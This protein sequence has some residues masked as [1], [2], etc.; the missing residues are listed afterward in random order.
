MTTIA[1]VIGWKFNHQ[2]GMRT[3][4]GVI[5]EFPGG[6]PT[7]AEQDTWTAEYLA[8]NILSERVDQAF[9]ETDSARAIF[10]AFFALENR[11]R[12]LEGQPPITK[13]Q[14]KKWFEGQLS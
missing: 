1:E 12:A 3:V 6:I 7:Q 4:N 13:V 8:R 5:T 11:I 9:P 2:P 14:L 10:N